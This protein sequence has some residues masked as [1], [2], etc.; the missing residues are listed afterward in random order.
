MP[1]KHKNT[2]M[3][4]VQLTPEMVQQSMENVAE[5]QPDANAIP[6]LDDLLVKIQTMLVEI[7]EQMVPGLSEEEKNAVETQICQKYNNEIPIKIINLML[8]EDPQTRYDN[9]ADL[10]DMFD[11]LRGVKEGRT[12]IVQ[13]QQAFNEKLNE[14]YVY[15]KFGGKEAF[16]K[17][18]AEGN[19][20]K[21]D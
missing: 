9:L 5:V 15:P 17:K 3:H 4:S 1:K 19:T 2:N 20:E 7:D 6:D 8:E 12:E 18:M 10:M 14:K 13:A 16:E 11:R 21:K